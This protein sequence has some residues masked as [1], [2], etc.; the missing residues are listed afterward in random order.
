MLHA[1]LATC[2]NYRA[3]SGL[4]IG[5]FAEVITIQI[6]EQMTE[7]S[8]AAPLVGIHNDSR[9]IERPH[10]AWTTT[11]HEAKTPKLAMRE[12][13]LAIDGLK[14][15][16]SERSPQ[17]I[18]KPMTHQNLGVQRSSPRSM[19]TQSI[20]SG[21]GQCPTSTGVSRKKAI[22][23]PAKQSGKTRANV[24]EWCRGL[25]TNFST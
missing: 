24:V 23:V 5:V 7:P 15:G 18:G 12:I 11:I 8:D 14:R 17:A 10:C 22:D 19:A 13:Y 1:V 16:I 25:F 9:I 4:F 3:R 6:A 20:A 2:L 21:V